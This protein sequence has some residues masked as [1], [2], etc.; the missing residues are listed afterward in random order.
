M[1]VL[2]GL[3]IWTL[4]SLLILS[5]CLGGGIID[6][7]EGQAVPEDGDTTGG[8]GDSGSGTTTGST[9]V[10]NNYHNNTT[11]IHEHY[12]TNNTVVEDSGVSVL[13]SNIEDGNGWTNLTTGTNQVV[14]I[15]DVWTFEMFAGPAGYDS[16]E[17]KGNEGWV[18]IVCDSMELTINS[19]GVNG[20]GNGF[21]QGGFYLPTDGNSCTYTFGANS[22]T[23]GVSVIYKIHNLV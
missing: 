14:Q 7:G 16:M 22:F 11:I 21:T 6:D 8:S 15:L 9:T 23:I 5:G 17:F 19:L 1:N 12:Y 20:N 18:D 10:V 4:V 3:Y 2:K 13:H